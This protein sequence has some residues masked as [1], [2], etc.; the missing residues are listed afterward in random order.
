MFANDGKIEC[1]IPVV[2]LSEESLSHLAEQFV[3]FSLASIAIARDIQ[4]M[5]GRNLYCIKCNCSCSTDSMSAN[6]VYHLLDPDGKSVVQMSVMLFFENSVSAA[7][8]MNIVATQ[9]A[10]KFV[11]R[12]D[13]WITLQICC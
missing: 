5:S 13:R 3:M 6:L 9:I 12:F 7:D 8:N 4:T 1:F 10:G 2:V 11:E